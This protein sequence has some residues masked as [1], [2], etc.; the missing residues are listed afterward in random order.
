MYEL[1]IAG[2]F[3]SA[4]FLRG[5]QGLCQN[6]HGHTWRVEVTISSAKLNELGLVFDFREIKKT[7]REFLAAMDHTC[8]N[9]LPAFAKDNPTTENLAK[10]IYAEFGKRCQPFTVKKVQVWESE[11]ASITYYE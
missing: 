11:N 1:S 5:Y 4:H 8:L 10:Y 3:S 7:L 2:H 6:L 9:E